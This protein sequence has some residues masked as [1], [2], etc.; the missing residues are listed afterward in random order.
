M[1]QLTLSLDDPCIGQ[2]RRDDCQ[3]SVDGARLVNAQRQRDVL[4]RELAGA[5]HGLTADELED[6]TGIKREFI[7][8][9][10]KQ[11]ER[12][13]EVESFGHRKNGNG[14]AVKIWYLRHQPRTVDVSVSQERL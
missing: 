11:M 14:I 7:A 13:G 1:S 10:L 9:R 12:W 4:A 8:S 3:S 6:R 5:L 2:T